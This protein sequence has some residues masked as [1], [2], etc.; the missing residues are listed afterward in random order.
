MVNEW[1]E[2]KAVDSRPYKRKLPR[3]RKG[4]RKAKAKRVCAAWN[5]AAA[6]QDVR[7][8]L[9]EKESESANADEEFGLFGSDFED[10][11]DV[12]QKDESFEFDLAAIIDEGQENVGEAARED[13]MSV[14]SAQAVPIGAPLRKKLRISGSTT[15]STP[16]VY[17]KPAVNRQPGFCRG[18]S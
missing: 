1:S 11:P 6:L 7:V 16:L 18:D 5:A 9:S 17:S 14:S 12:D 8:H 4:R 3:G 2:L 13:T 10:A 15:L